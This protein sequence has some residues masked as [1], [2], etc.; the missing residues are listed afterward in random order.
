MPQPEGE[1]K[2]KECSAASHPGQ[3]GLPTQ[4]LPTDTRHDLH[5]TKPVERNAYFLLDL[6][7]PA[8]KRWN[9]C[10]HDD[11][12]KALSGSTKQKR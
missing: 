9:V 4:C 8:K 7:A 1:E 10:W 6:D 2:R 5:K 11:E 3:R 12:H